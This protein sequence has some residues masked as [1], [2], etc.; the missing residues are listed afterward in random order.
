MQHPTKSIK[1]SALC[2]TVLATSFAFSVGVAVAAPTGFQ[3]RTLRV[4]NGVSEDHPNG[5][6]EKKMSQCAAEKSGGKMKIQ[7]FWNGMLGNELATIQQVR[8]GSLEMVLASPAPITG[9]VPELGVFDLPFLF[10]NSTEARRILDGK[11]GDWFN[12]KMMNSGLVN[13]AWMESGFRHTTNSKRP[14]TKWEDF[15][16]IKMRVMQSP[17]YLDT[18]KEM[19]ANAVPMAFSEVYSALEMKAVDGQEN[20]VNNI[21]NMKFYEVQKYLSFTKHSYTPTLVMV[22]KKIWDTMSPEEQKT[23]KDCAVEGRDVQRKANTAAE[24]K[25]VEMMKSKGI[26][27]NDVSSAELARIRDKTKPISDAYAS[28]LNQEAVSM[29]F[30]ELKLI[31]SGK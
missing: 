15:Q 30:G 25:S 10:D 11:I 19:G 9:I 12:A 31:R 8:T 13:L 28:K 5:D 22:S 16:G 26:V 24:T 23:L 17:I 3:E 20:P 7:L 4:A 29:V 27:V 21:E 6:G 18:F 14:I 2:T 1:V